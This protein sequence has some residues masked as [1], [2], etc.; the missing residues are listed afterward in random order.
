MCVCVGG[1]EEGGRGGGGGGGGESKICTKL[2]RKKPI[3]AQTL[4]VRLIVGLGTIPS[5]KQLVV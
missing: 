2:N 5:L 4:L 1:R 3:L